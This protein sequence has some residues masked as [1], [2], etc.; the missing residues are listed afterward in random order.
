MDGKEY[1]FYDRRR[2]ADPPRLYQKL[3]SQA[4]RSVIIWDPFHDCY[5]FRTVFGG[6]KQDGIFVELLTICDNLETKADIESLADTILSAINRVDVP[7]CAVTVFAL[8]KAKFRA[9]YGGTEWHDRFLILD[10]D[11]VYLIGNSIDAQEQTSKSFGI[12]KLVETDDI[13]L[14]V[15]A[16]NA[17]RQDIHDNMNGYKVTRRRV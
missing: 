16:Y 11:N 8:K 4:T 1:H 14:V 17:Y 5:D 13:N 10:G 15:D 7:S 9:C 2:T 3:L 12:M 6:I